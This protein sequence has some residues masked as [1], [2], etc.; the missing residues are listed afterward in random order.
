MSS[1]AVEVCPSIELRDGDLARKLPVTHNNEAGT[2]FFVRYKG[3]V[4][5]YLN[6][7]PHMGSE[8]DWEGSIF[9]RAGDQLM[10][11]RHGATFTPDTGVCT[12][13]PCKPSK[14]LELKTS[15]EQ[16]DG[17]QTVLWWPEGKTIPGN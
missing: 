6:R 13:G 11:A 7:C 12:G 14:L 2:A 9:T 5:G 1:P 8:L 16:R 15:E 4:H 10:C 17:R 3:Q